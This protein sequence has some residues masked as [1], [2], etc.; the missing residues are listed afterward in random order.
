MCRLIIEIEIQIETH[1]AILWCMWFDCL[2]PRRPPVM[3]TSTH[4]LTHTHTHLKLVLLIVLVSSRGLNYV[5][6]TKLPA[7]PALITHICL[8]LH[9]HRSATNDSWIQFSLANTQTLTPDIHQLHL[10]QPSTQGA[11]RASMY[12][13]KT[14]GYATTMLISSH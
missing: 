4:S 8:T 13:L 1:G 10:A 9:S 5:D 6:K 11:V 12:L 2:K 7:Q 3:W 14:A